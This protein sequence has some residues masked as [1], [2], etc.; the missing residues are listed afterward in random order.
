MPVMTAFRRSFLTAVLA[1]GA[2]LGP[3]AGRALASDQALPAA[4]PAGPAQ[5]APGWRKVVQRVPV[6]VLAGADGAPLLLEN[7]V[8]GVFLEPAD[9]EAFL[10]ILR[11][12]EPKPPA[13][14]RVMATS[15]ETVMQSVAAG[16]LSVAFIPK[17]TNVAAARRIK[18]SDSFPEAPVFVVQVR[19]DARP[20]FVTTRQADEDVVLAFLDYPDAARHADK[21]RAAQG[22][23]AG[24]VF[25]GV[26]GLA[27]FLNAARTDPSL[28]RVRIV[29]S[30]PA[31]AAAAL[32][33]D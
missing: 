1:A 7:H 16:A 3:T 24:T 6:F 9:A 5:E 29:P 15:L 25:V 12:R 30:T 31:R 10:A 22:P 8:A 11:L 13:G 28:S 23:G 33:Q 17:E 27:G 19:G 4:A 21:V 20:G 32:R 14:V 26:A 18:R 2:A